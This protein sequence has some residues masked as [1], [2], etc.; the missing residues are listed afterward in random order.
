VRA[1]ACTAVQQERGPRKNK[2]RRRGVRVTSRHDDVIAAEN[3]EN[4]TQHRATKSTARSTTERHHGGADA[5]LP[6]ET[7]GCLSAFTAVR[8]TATG[9]DFKPTDLVASSNNSLCNNDNKNV[10]SLYASALHISSQRMAL[11]SF[12]FIACLL[13]GTQLKAF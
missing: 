7:D 8:C 10:T 5:L 12:R 4:R 2:G 1:T 9:S 6:G 11:L 3:P 13:Y